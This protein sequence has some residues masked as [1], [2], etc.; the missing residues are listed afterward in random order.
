MT[1]II[2]HNL[3]DPDYERIIEVWQKSGLPIKPRGRDSY[4]NL[5]AQIEREPEYNIGAYLDGRL[6]GLVIASSDGRKGWINR[7]AVLPEFRGHDIA[8]NLIRKAENA[9][10]KTGIMITAC[11]ILD[12][13]LPSIRLFESEDYS[14]WPGVLYFRKTF[15][16]NI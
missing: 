16:E 9:L 14:N 1:D 13:N 15:D 2:Y 5:A 3:A 8:I 11:L 10:R 4:E 6:I 12:D 7:L